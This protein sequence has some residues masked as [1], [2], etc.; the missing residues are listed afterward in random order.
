MAKKNINVKAH[1]RKVPSGGTTRVKQH[2]RRI[3]NVKKIE[4]NIL[5]NKSLSNEEF[6]NIFKEF[7]EKNDLI[8]E[9]SGNTI[10]IGDETA[11]RMITIDIS[12][13]KINVQYTEYE[14][15]RRISLKEALQHLDRFINIDESIIR[16]KILT[17][18]YENQSKIILSQ[19]EKQL[20]RKKREISNLFEMLNENEQGKAENYAYD[21]GM[22]EEAAARKLY[23]KEYENIFNIKI[24]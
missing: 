4:H 14:M 16:E 15:D 11:D 6:F 12:N 1:N 2:T 21:T 8:Y 10:I 5:I 19:R 24:K 17:K 9:L 23:G 3:S 13:D 18:I 20:K 22:T 7:A